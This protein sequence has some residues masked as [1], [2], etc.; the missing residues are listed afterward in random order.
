MS[1]HEAA[2]AFE[3]SVS[4]AIAVG[5]ALSTDRVGAA[6]PM[7]GKRSALDAHKDWLLESIAVEPDLTLEEMTSQNGDAK[8]RFDPTINYGHVLTQVY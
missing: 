7:G 8:P 4:S 6:K 1:C 2:A 5:R 3:V